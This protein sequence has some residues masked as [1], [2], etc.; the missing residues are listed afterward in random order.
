MVSK[1]LVAVDGSPYGKK[2]LEYAIN[3]AKTYGSKLTAIY[4][5]HK[6]VYGAAQEAG[7]SATRSLKQDLEEQGKM[8]LAEAKATA[9][10][11]GVEADT[12]LVHGLPAEEI[13]R[14]A[15]AEKDDMIVVGSRGRTGATAFFLGSVSERVTHHA[16]CLVLIVR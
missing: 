11:A 5:V 7:F 14:T 2:T 1:I 4:V 8:T 6:R 10:A 3:L 12:V 16:K 13:V 9:Q 15:D